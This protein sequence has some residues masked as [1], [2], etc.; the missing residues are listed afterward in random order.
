[1]WPNN[2]IFI[3]FSSENGDDSDDDDEIEIGGVTQDYRC[4]L[5][6]TLLTD[7]LTAYVLSVSFH[8]FTIL[9]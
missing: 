4:P 5:T 1:M 8:A 2:I 6:L 7:P 3:L 9:V